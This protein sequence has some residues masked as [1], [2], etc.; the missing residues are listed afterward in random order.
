MQKPIVVNKHAK[1]LA[2]LLRVGNTILQAVVKI[3]NEIRLF[4]PGAS[5]EEQQAELLWRGDPF[6]RVFLVY[7]DQDDRDFLRENNRIEEINSWYFIR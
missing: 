6:T 3:N 7:L 2:E 4:A 5:E 1:R